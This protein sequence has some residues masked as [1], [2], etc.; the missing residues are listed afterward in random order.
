MTGAVLLPLA[1]EPASAVPHSVF[2]ALTQ[3]RY[4]ALLLAHVQRG[5]LSA[6]FLYQQPDKT[7][8]C[9]DKLRSA[10]RP[11]RA[12]SAVPRSAICH[13]NHNVRMEP[14]TNDYS[15]VTADLLVEIRC[16][17]TAMAVQLQARV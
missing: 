1:R 11:P 4:A 7:R 15:P 13:M 6:P 3:L 5:Y 2:A 10:V 8:R 9:A 16:L 17:D 12:A 14:D